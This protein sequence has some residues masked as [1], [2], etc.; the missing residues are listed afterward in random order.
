[1]TI[2]EQS[3][4]PRTAVPAGITDPVERARAELKAALAAIE[5]RANVPKRL[6]KSSA[7][8][9]AK[10]RQMARTNPA[11]LALGVIGLAAAVGGTVWMIARVLSR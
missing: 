5:E 2:S 7:R 10:A 1:M 11:S 3:P 8:C 4:M 6:A 9:T